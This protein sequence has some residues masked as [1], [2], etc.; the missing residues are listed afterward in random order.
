MTDGVEN[1]AA[2]S[3]CTIAGVGFFLASLRLLLWLDSKRFG[4]V[5]PSVGS[6]VEADFFYMSPLKAWSCE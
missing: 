1:N 5:S 2:W 6:L 4:L 3:A